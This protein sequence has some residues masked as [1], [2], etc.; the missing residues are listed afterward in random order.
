MPLPMF[1]ELRWEIA[2][3]VTA[4]PADVIEE[5]MLQEMADAVGKTLDEFIAYLREEKES[6]TC[7]LCGRPASHLI[8]CKGC[9]GGAWTEHEFMHGEGVLSQIRQALVSDLGRVRDRHLQKADEGEVWP[10]DDERVKYATGNAYNHGGCSIC[11]TCWYHTIP[12]DAY[13]TC[14]LQLYGEAFFSSPVWLPM[15]A[16]Q[17]VIG[18]KDDGERKQGLHDWFSMVWERWVV[19]WNTVEGEEA[20]EDVAAWRGSLLGAFSMRLC[21]ARQVDVDEE[22]LAELSLFGSLIK[23]GGQHG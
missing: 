20:Q 12:T 16:L 17:F 21:P 7:P 4:N 5:Q 23:E 1:E 9:G 22:K 11:A 18:I 2:D 15:S 13:Q 6:M 3:L 19:S 10:F 8:G 14:P